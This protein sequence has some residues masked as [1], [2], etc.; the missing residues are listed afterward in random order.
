MKKIIVLL[1]AAILSVS[2][3]SC[4]DKSP[5]TI[6]GDSTV[7]KTE[8]EYDV[9][10]R[11]F[12][13]QKKDLNEGFVKTFDSSGMK[14]IEKYVYP[15]GEMEPAEILF[16]SSGVM[17]LNSKI[18]T[19]TMSSTFFNYEFMNEGKLLKI[20]FVDSKLN[21]NDYA[22]MENSSSSVFK[23]DRNDN[24]IIYHIKNDGFFFFNWGFYKE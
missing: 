20:K 6:S 21:F 9:I 23:I 3:I 10:K 7:T 14:I 1:F 8:S 15:G 12:N 4:K 16:L 5:E 2:I 13:E 19:D 22:D 24:T 17:V 18:F 11:S